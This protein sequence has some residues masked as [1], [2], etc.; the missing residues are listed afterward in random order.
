MNYVWHCSGAAAAA[1]NVRRQKGTG[2]CVLFDFSP[3]SADS[4]LK[5]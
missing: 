5:G 1:G 2:S 3:A 4:N